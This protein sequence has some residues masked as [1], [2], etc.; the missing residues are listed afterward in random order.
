MAH[1][2]AQ[3]DKIIGAVRYT[4]AKDGEDLI[5]ISH[6]AHTLDID[7]TVIEQVCERNDNLFG[8]TKIGSDM[9]LW[10]KVQ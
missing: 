1:S 4:Q 7:T 3:T 5:L 10:I 6:L 9:A 8:L 2:N